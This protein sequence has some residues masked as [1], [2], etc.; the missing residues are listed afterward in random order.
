[1]CS[2]KASE[3]M[4]GIQ[5]A[6]V[7]R[8]I[9]D[10][11]EKTSQGRHRL[12]VTECQRNVPVFKIKRKFLLRLLKTWLRYKGDFFRKVKDVSDDMT[13][14]NDWF[15]LR[16]NS[17]F[18]TSWNLQQLSPNLVTWLVFIY[19]AKSGETAAQKLMAGVIVD[20]FVLFHWHFSSWLMW[21]VTILCAEL[22]ALDWNA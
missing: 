14:T 5:T 12:W 16:S 22:P 11:L 15:P 18:T 1:M 3:N 7:C 4:P 13:E 20:S 19:C 21:K 8:T 9:G 6:M 10:R 2:C 17:L